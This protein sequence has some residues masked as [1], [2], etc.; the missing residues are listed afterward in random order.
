MNCRECESEA[1]VGWYRE[2]KDA[3][4]LCWKCF[5]NYKRVTEE[6]KRLGYFKL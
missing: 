2:G 4:P 5:H 3:I 1:K 6:E